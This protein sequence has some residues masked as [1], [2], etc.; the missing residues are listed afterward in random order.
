[1][2]E[3]SVKPYIPGHESNNINYEKAIESLIEESKSSGGGKDIE[4]TIGKVAEKGVDIIQD[5][6]DDV[7]SPEI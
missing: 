1:M 7:T 5:K 4:K 2:S 6:L 3:N